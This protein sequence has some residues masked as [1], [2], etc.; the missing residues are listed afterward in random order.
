[1]REGPAGLEGCTCSAYRYLKWVYWAAAAGLAP[2]VVYLYLTQVPRALAH[3]LRVLVFG[4]ILVTILGALV[5]AWMYSR[6]SSLTVMVATYT[7]TTAFISIWFRLLTRGGGSNLGESRPV[8]VVAA[9][10]VVLLC[11]IVIASSRPSRRKSRARWLPIVLVI[12]ALGLIPSLA[13]A[14]IVSPDMR[15]EHHLKIAWTGLDV[16]ELVAMAVTG[17]ELHRR[18]ASVVVP[19]TIT[20]AL[21]LCDAWINIIPVQGATRM[22]A[23]AF[24][25]LEVP[26]AILSLWIALQVSWRNS[27]RHA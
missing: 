1:M 22:Q 15:I 4:I 20:G 21:L 24:A 19:V 18:S 8:F 6:R 17:L 27:G 5:S 23:I 16:F 7:A 2:W 26:L 25:F 10:I 9:G 12:A 3:Q 14:L 13:I 11:V